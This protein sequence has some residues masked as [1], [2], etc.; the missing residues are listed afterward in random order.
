MKTPIPSKTELNATW[1][2]PSFFLSI[3]LQLTRFSKTIAPS[4]DQQGVSSVRFVTAFTGMH[5]WLECDFPG[6]GRYVKRTVSNSCHL[7]CCRYHRNMTI[8]CIYTF[9]IL[10]SNYLLANGRRRIVCWYMASSRQIRLQCR[11]SYYSSWRPRSCWFDFRRICSPFCP[12][13]LHPQHV[14]SLG[15]LEFTSDWR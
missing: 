8:N 12:K 11:V 1:P 14:K 10:F 6:F 5:I 2:I 4:L 13:R 3:R 9:D 15:P 7:L